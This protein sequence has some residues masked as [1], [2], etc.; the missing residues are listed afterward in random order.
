M[1]EHPRLKYMKQLMDYWFVAR[2]NLKSRS[3]LHNLILTKQERQKHLDLLQGYF[4]KF[5]PAKLREH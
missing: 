1:K 2:K 5:K 3:T 4:K